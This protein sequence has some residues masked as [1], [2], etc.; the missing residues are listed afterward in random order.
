MEKAIINVGINSGDLTGNTE[1][2]IQAAIDYISFLGGGTVKISEGVFTIN[3]A[4][5]MRSNVILEGS[6]DKTVL[7]KADEI[8]SP[9]LADADLHESKITVKNPE[10]FKP[11][12]TVTVRKT[13]GR[14]EGFS[15]TVAVITGKKDNVLYFDRAMLITKSLADGIEA[16][17]AFPVISAY[18]CKDI[19]I[20]NLKV[21]GNKENNSSTNGC[22]HAGIYF[23][24]T[25]N[26]LI[27]D[28][29]VF[30]YNGD[31]ISYQNS[32]NIDVIKCVCHQNAS[33]G[34]HPGSGTTGTRIIDSIFTENGG[35]GIFFCWRVTQGLVD[36][37]YSAKNRMSGFSIGHK[38]INNIIRNSRFEENNYYGMFF[39]LEND[40]MGANFNTVEN[41]IFKDN[42]IP[43]SAYGTAG[44]RLRGTTNNV[45]FINNK[46]IYE[47]YPEANTV[48]FI[49]EEGTHSITLEGTEFIGC[50]QEQSSKY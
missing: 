43:G 29:K 13:N 7:V 6:G 18:D 27:E 20:K 34:V 30:N 3:S 44:V 9:I 19:A 5:H 4:L 2:A 1:F 41:N 42:G 15:D 21:E 31:G 48:G 16:A 26:A 32:K 47:K 35:D 12:M 39:R 22:M 10:L 14:H 50:K 46:I 38:D 37:C 33:L 45:K 17:T 8:S 23:F 40:P 11:G 36:N 24:Q 25:E 49:F 28:V